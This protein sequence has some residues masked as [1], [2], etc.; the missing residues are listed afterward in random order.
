VSDFA[1]AQARASM[2]AGHTMIVLSPTDTIFLA[3]VT[4]LAAEDFL[5]S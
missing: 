4:T 1:A 3:G 5:F 2:V